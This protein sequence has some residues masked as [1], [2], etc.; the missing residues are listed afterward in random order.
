MPRQYGGG[1]VGDPS[2]LVSFILTT[3][4]TTIALSSALFASVR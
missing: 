1:A 2:G 4:L 3:I